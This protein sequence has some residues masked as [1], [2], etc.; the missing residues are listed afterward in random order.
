MKTYEHII[1]S[2]LDNSYKFV[3]LSE[4][5]ALGCPATNHFV[6][7]HDVDKSPASLPAI[8]NVERTLNVRSTTY[9]RVA[10]AEYNPF[11]YQS[12]RIFKDAADKGTEIGLHTS[13]YE[14]ALINEI[15]PISVLGG[16]LSILRTFFNIKGVAPHRDINYMHNSLPFLE[17]NWSEIQTNLSLQYH[18]YERPIMDNVVYVNEGFN[19]HL[20]WR[21]LSPIDAM[22]TFPNRSIYMLTH[23]HWWFLTHPFEVA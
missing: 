7:R 21:S 16:E 1:K 12:L 17:A 8:I 4:F 18:A 13:F 22:T 2:A 11:S 6:I 10:G 23:P 3:T 19:P 20:C 9:V 14:Y 5:V 15:D